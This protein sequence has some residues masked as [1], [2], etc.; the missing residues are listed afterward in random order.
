M[1]EGWSGIL[2]VAAI[3]EEPAMPAKKYLVTLTEEERRTL[4]ELIK[5]GTLPARKLSR[6]HILLLADEGRTD[7]E[8]E[9]VKPFWTRI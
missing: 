8:T 9:C 4:R 3:L 1:D 5:K 7:D 2:W 6:A